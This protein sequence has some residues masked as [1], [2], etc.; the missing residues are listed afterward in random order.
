M[1]SAASSQGVCVCEGHLLRAVRPA[2]CVDTSEQTGNERSTAWGT[3]GCFMH[4]PSEVLLSWKKTLEF[5]LLFLQKSFAL[6]N[7]LFWNW[8]DLRVHL[9][10]PCC[11]YFTT[12]MLTHS[13]KSP[14]CTA[15]HL[16]IPKCNNINT[17][18]SSLFCS[19]G[20]KMIVIVPN[21]N[22]LKSPTFVFPGFIST[23]F[24]R[25]ISYSSAWLWFTKA[26]IICVFT[27][28]LEPINTHRAQLEITLLLFTSSSSALC[29][30]G[31][32]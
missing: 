13:N 7:F 22:L 6:C 4:R 32:H 28:M 12:V 29:R 2:G 16:R 19:C 20:H 3:A 15:L 5:Q 8:S 10:W 21:N 14:Q 25:V 24:S 26:A 23:S 27:I 30:S 18:H 1:C 17:T 11:H 9:G 31:L